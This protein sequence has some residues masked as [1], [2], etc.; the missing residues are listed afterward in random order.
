M[1]RAFEVE[2]LGDRLG[3]QGL[4]PAALQGPHI[5]PQL[6]L[7]F[8]DKCQRSRRKQRDLD[9]AFRQIAAL[10]TGWAEQ[11]LLDLRLECVFVDLAGQVPS[12]DAL[13]GRPEWSIADQWCYTR[14]AF[15]RACCGHLGVDR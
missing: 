3:Q 1:Q 5:G 13:A 11:Y 12:F 6:G 7:G 2:L 14:F 4:E 8:G 9:I 10:P 15:G